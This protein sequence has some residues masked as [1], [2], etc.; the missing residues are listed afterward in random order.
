MPKYLID[1]SVL[2]G[3][4][5]TRDTHH[6][7]CKNF[8]IEHEGEH[9]YFSIHSLFEVHAARSCRTRGRSFTA[10]PGKHKLRDQIF[11][12]IDRKFYDECQ[13]FKLFDEFAGLRGMDLIYACC[14]K[15]G[16]F[17]LVTCDQD[18]D[19]YADKISV[20]RLTD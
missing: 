4:A 18:F 20:L 8:F 19:Q 11:I 3:W 10:L 15:I 6:D 14:A 12:D 17:T 7:I 16:R 9:L 13:R 2:H 5:N 1:A